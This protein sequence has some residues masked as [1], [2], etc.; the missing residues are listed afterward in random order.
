MKLWDKMQKVN[1]S[2][3]ENSLEFV[4]IISARKLQYMEN[5]KKVFPDTEIYQEAIKNTIKNMDNSVFLT[6]YEIQNKRLQRNDKI[7]FDGCTIKENFIIY[8]KKLYPR[9]YKKLFVTIQPSLRLDTDGENPLI[10]VCGD[11]FF[12]F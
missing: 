11:T 10:C 8:F 4:I 5:F 7:E 9:L 12:S 1:S 3:L 6:A 2:C